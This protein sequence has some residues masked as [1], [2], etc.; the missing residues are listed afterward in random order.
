MTV[1]EF[2]QRSLERG[3]HFTAHWV[4]RRLKEL[5]GDTM[6]ASEGTF[7]QVSALN[8]ID[9]RTIANYVR[10]A[11]DNEL[12]RTGRRPTIIQVPAFGAAP[13]STDQG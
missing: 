7:I 9:D 2:I 10:K 13:E 3:W 11:V 12:A 8:N 1:E 4:M 5:Q 6:Q